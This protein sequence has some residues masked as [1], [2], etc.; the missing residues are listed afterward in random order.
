M[1]RAFCEALMTRPPVA[2]GNT[3][4]WY[5]F[6][7]GS[8][9]RGPNGRRDTVVHGPHGCSATSMARSSPQYPSTLVTATQR[10]SR[11]RGCI[12]FSAW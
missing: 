4:A 8:A 5:V 11:N 2:L 9:P 7:S 6:I 1:S 3:W 12:G 10:P